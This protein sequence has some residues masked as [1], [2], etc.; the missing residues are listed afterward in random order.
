[1]GSITQPDETAHHRSLRFESVSGIHLRVMQFFVDET[2]AAE[3][4][5]EDTLILLSL[6]SPETGNEG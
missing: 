5:T 4:V 2:K 1:M 6:L 3:V